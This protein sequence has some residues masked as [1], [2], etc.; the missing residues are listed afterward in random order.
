MTYQ[1]PTVRSSQAGFEHLGDLAKATKHLF[2]DE[3]ELDMSR[4]TSFDTN[5]AA[6]LGVVLA[7]VARRFNSVSI[8][9]VP[10]SVK[11]DLIGS[12]FLTYFRYRSAASTL[13]ATMLSTTPFRRFRLTDVGAFQEYISLMLTSGA[14]PAM[15][16][17]MLLRF[18]KTV[19]EVYQNAV[20]HSESNY[21]VFVCGQSFA[22]ES[23]IHFTIADCGVGIRGA[24]RGYLNDRRI[25]SIQALKWA[26][27]PR[28]TTKTGKQPGGLGMSLVKKLSALNGGRIWIISRFSL[29]KFY[30]GQ[31]NFR[32]MT[33]DFP[34]TAVTIEINTAD[35]GQYARSSEVS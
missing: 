18:K 15:S 24:V 29:Y 4:A 28:N 14:F 22:R 30:C 21:G 34:G 32:K 20:T 8:V 3:L 16:Q 31:E 6:P 1:L 12:R 7:R 13:P 10:L 19:F 11:P 5:M 23:L 33:S 27:T 9:S 25:S 26:L 2:A 35:A 17:K